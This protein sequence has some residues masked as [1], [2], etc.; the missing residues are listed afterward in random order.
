VNK[1]TD[2]FQGVSQ[3]IKKVSWPE[4]KEIID[5]TIVVF[6]SLIFLSLVVGTIDYCFSKLITL[7][8]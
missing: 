8:F 5:S 4:R 2:F 7:I 1:F 6:V 3:E